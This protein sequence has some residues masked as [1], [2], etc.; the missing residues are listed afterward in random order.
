MLS[1]LLIRSIQIL[2]ICSLSVVAS[3]QQLVTGEVQVRSYHFDLTDEEIEYRLY[4]PNSYRA[5]VASPLIVLLHGLGGTPRIIEYDGIREEA[6][7]HGYIVVAP[8]G[9]N[10]RGWY[11]LFGPGKSFFNDGPDGPAPDNIGLLSETDVINVFEMVNEEFNIDPKR[12]YLMGHSMGGGGTMYLGGKYS[13]YWAALALLAPALFGS[14]D[15]LE[16]IKH[17]PVFIAQGDADELISVNMARRWVARMEEL[18]MTHTYV[19]I[20]GGDHVDA[21]AS[22]VPLIAQIFDFF[23]KHSQ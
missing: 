5:D 4:V 14:T 23:D 11:G 18:E 2:F 3:A 13:Q 17:I 19:E 22:N 1:K 7:Q 20:A 15:Q 21:I 16:A 9:Y 8:Y 6:E 10:K 12:T